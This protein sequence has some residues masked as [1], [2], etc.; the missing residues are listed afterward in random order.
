MDVASST[1][2]QTIT[3]R[4]VCGKLKLSQAAVWNGSIHPCRI[5]ET[6]R[7][8]AQ[9]ERRII[10]TLEP[11]MNQHRLVVDRT[12]IERD[13][14]DNDGLTEEQA[15]RFRLFYQMT[16]ITSER[17]A[18]GKDDRLDALA[19]AVHYWTERLAQDTHLA[20]EQSRAEALHAE[21]TRFVSH[22]VGRGFRPSEHG[23]AIR[24]RW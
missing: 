5:E 8:Q 10:D 22:A 12:L 20:A 24:R 19:L 7:S 6:E 13:F 15:Q 23:S 21:L 18:L 14:K 16:R 2:L 9:K 17:G 11:V 4:R 3:N 1:H